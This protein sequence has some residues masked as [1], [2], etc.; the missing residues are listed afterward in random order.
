MLWYLNYEE[1]ANVR[2]NINLTEDS[3]IIQIKVIN[4]DYQY[5]ALRKVDFDSLKIEDVQ[6][7]MKQ[8]EFF[9]VTGHKNGKIRLWSIPEFSLNL[10]FDVITEVLIIYIKELVGFE[11][12]PN[13]LKLIAFY[14]SG[15][16]RFFDMSNSKCLGKYRSLSNEHYTFVR[17]LPDGKHVFLLDN[18]GIIFLMKVE[19]WDPIGIQMHQVIFNL[20]AVV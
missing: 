6:A 4:K 15:T 18:Y 7:E 2:I 13:D 16:L 19:K 5:Y 12:S 3:E 8:N 17:F 20:N 9:I 11:T 10:T 14:K 1:K